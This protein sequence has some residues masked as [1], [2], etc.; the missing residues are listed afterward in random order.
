MS[1]T[2]VGE[3]PTELSAQAVSLLVSRE[4]PDLL[5]GSILSTDKGSSFTLPSVPNLFDN[6]TQFV[7]SKVGEN[8]KIGN[9]LNKL[10]TQKTVFHNPYF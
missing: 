1:R 6:G 8:Q 5:A 2:L 10:Q 7:D 9:K 4:E 3:E